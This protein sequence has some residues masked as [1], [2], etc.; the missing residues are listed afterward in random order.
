MKT[1]VLF[2]SHIVNKNT[3]SRFYDIKAGL[4]LET[5]LIWCLN[6]QE[7]QALN[8]LKDVDVFDFTKE[9]FD[10]LPYTVFSDEIWFNTNLIMML[11]YLRNPQYDY[12]WFI[13]Y[14]VV[15]T[16]EWGLLLQSFKESKSDLISSHVERYVKSNADWHWWNTIEF[17]DKEI[18]LVNRVKSFNPIY[19]L[20]ERSLVFLHKYLSNGNA[21]YYE[22]MMPTA[23][24]NN[25]YTIEDFGGTGCFVKPENRNRFYIQ[26]TYTNCG[27]MRYF[28]NYS[29]E[30]ISTLSTKN[31]LFHPVKK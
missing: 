28:P 14:D 27:T 26:G 29:L 11:F 30:E 12:Y 5:K 17:R 10:E 21:G 9:D 22:V 23:L 15:F 6:K 7:G 31:K 4:P 24:Y 19:R 1:I 20:S 2:S 8:L 25:G 3:I 18:P 16:G 13:E